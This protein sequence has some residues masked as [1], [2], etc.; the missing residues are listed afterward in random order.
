MGKNFLPSFREHLTVRWAMS[1]NPKILFQNE[2]FIAAF[3]PANCLSTPPRFPDQDSRPVLGRELEKIFN[4]KVYPI[5]RLDFEVCGLILYALNE[6]AHSIASQV[7]EKRMV[8]KTYNAFSALP[9]TPQD[10]DP[11]QQVKWDEILK[12]DDIQEGSQFNWECRLLRGKKRSYLHETGKKAVTFA[13]VEKILPDSLL[14]TLKPQT[15][16]AHQLRF[17]LFRH[18]C[19]IVGDRLYANKMK[20]ANEGIALQSVSLI[21]QSAELLKMGLPEKLEVPKELQLIDA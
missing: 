3:K 19:P 17:E 14:W 12:I 13:R 11:N 4:L 2:D 1:I 10:L 6:N 21:F 7:F 18:G 20:F 8:N 9:L 5:H 16:R 15:G